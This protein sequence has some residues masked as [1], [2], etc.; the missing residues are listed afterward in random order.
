MA[1]VWRGGRMMTPCLSHLLRGAMDSGV[2]KPIT[3]TMT[4]IAISSTNQLPALRSLSSMLHFN[5]G[6]AALG[7]SGGSGPPDGQYI[8]LNNLR[9]NPGANK[10]GRRVGRGIGSSK[11]KT[12]GRGHKGQKARS[13]G[14]PKPGFEGGQT[15]LRL[16]VPKRGFHNPFT[17][18]YHPLN[19]QRLQ[20]WIQTGRLD[21]SQVITMKDLRDSGAVRKQIGDG[22]KLLADGA[23]DFSIKVDL[24]ITAA[25]TAAREAV[26][27]AG[28]NVTTVYYN[29]L[30]L[31]ALT[32]PEWFEKKNRL[33]PRPARPPPKLVG[34][35]DVRGNLPPVFNASNTSSA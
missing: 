14:G 19:L 20:E 28:G 24:Q 21:A 27:K 18:V 32:Q 25:S 8:S 13:G 22:V 4:E 11:G 17:R 26:E 31:R 6:F 2:V 29:K 1:T 9:D 33:L 15:P 35:F 7:E 30:G 16:R 10:T 12:A 5:R 34:R 3:P 23:E